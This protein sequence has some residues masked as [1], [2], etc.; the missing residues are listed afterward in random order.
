[1]IPKHDLKAIKSMAGISMSI[2]KKVG[3]LPQIDTF[4]EQKRTQRLP[5]THT[6]I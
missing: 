6:H 4:S 1:M 5:H 2:D 3:K